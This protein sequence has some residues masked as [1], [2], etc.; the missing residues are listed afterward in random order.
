MARNLPQNREACRS[1]RALPVGRKA[2]RGRSR[3]GGAGGSV[4]R[5]RCG[6]AI[7]RVRFAENEMNYCARCQTEGRILADRSLS[8]LLKDDWLGTIEELEG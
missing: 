8:R 4:I 1:F 6:T 2:K 7:Q 5:Q 3:E